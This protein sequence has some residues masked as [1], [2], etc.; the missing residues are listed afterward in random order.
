MKTGDKLLQPERFERIRNIL[1]DKKTAKV[2]ELSRICEVSENT[3]RRDLLELEEAGFCIRTKGGATQAVQTGSR[4]ESPF[5]RRMENHKRS[6]HEIAV[7]AAEL[8]RSGDT[9]I[10]DSGTSPAELAYELLEKKHITVITTSLA[11]AGILSDAPDITLILPGGIVHRTS[12]SLTGQPAE[13]FFQ[14]IHADILFLAVKAVHLESGLSDHTITESSVKC[15]M[16]DCAE[17]IVVLADHS[18]LNKTALSRTCDIDCVDIIITD[19][20]ADKDYTAALRE[21]GIEVHIA[22]SS[23]D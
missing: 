23:S 2:S 14:S 15:R 22:E 12:Q 21:R 18:K 7:K 4:L 8:I 3:I 11:A 19:S 9:I 17:T 16:I 20:Q 13:D 10:L 1:A 5:L 6:K